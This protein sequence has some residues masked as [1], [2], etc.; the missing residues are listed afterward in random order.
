MSQLTLSS[1]AVPWSVGDK[2]TYEQK[3]ENT[4]TIEENTADGLVSSSSLAYEFEMDYVITSIDKTDLEVTFDVL[5]F[6]GEVDN[7]TMGYNSTSFGMSLGYFSATYLQFE[8]NNTFYLRSFYYPSQVAI[9]VD[10]DFKDIADNFDEE[11]NSSK[12]VDTY[13]D[14]DDLDYYEFTLGNLFANMSSWSINDASTFADVTTGTTEETREYSMEFDI[15]GLLTT[16][17][18]DVIDAE[19]VTIYVVYDVATISLNWEYDS[20]GILKSFSEA[21]KYVYVKNDATITNE[22]TITVKQPG[23]SL[24]AN[25][26]PGFELYLSIL[27][28]IAVPIVLRR[29]KN[30]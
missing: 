22:Y 11:L 17:Y 16:S 13:I 21:E 12:L 1:A 23:F 15:S 9:L 3:I 8:D 25:S 30:I 7:T 18:T 14:W 29:R 4:S 6:D 20:D 28:L 5:E 2:F 19:V 26:I 24:D 10:P 27:G